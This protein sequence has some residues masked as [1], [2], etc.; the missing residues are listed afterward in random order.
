MCWG[1]VLVLALIEGQKENKPKKERIRVKMSKFQIAVL[2]LLVVTLIYAVTLALN[3]WRYCQIESEGFD[4]NLGHWIGEPELFFNTEEGFKFFI[5]GVGLF[6][7]WIATVCFDLYRCGEKTKKVLALTL[8]F[9]LVFLIFPPVKAA[10]QSSTPLIRIGVLC[11]GDEE[12]M[13]TQRT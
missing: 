11:A 4:P 1:L 5:G 6:F 13:A 8:L 10:E 12:F 2:V 3:V 9:P 7:T